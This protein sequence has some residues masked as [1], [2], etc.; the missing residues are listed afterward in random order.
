ME[1]SI[2]FGW[3]EDLNQFWNNSELT[4]Q[5]W[6]D[7]DDFYEK[8]LRANMWMEPLVV[9]LDEEDGMQYRLWLNFLP[10]LSRRPQKNGV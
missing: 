5:E 1:V 4:D 10:G 9:V 2:Y 7:R 8:P 3:I 6:Y